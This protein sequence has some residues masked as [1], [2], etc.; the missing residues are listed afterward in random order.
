MKL[1]SNS[2]YKWVSSITNALP[3]QQTC[4]PVCAR[5][6]QGVVQFKPFTKPNQSSVHGSCHGILLATETKDIRQ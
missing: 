3:N 6:L 1:L 2:H 5:I 4:L